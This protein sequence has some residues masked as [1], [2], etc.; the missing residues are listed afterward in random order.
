LLN[1]VRKSL[2]VYPVRAWNRNSPC[3]KIRIH[4]RGTKRANADPID[5]DPTTMTE[6]VVKTVVND[7]RQLANA[8]RALAMD[9]VQRANSGHPGMPMGMADIA[10][11]LFNDF[12]RHN[13]ANPDWWNRDRFVVSN[14]HGSMLL[15]AL[16]HLTGYALSIEDLKNFRQMHA[17]TPGHPEYG[18][19]PGVETTT[20]PLGQGLAN[21]VGMALAEKLLAARFNRDDLDLVDHWTW[22]FAGD[23]CLME[24]ISHEVCSLAGT[25]KLGKLVLFYD[26]NGISIDGQTS[27]WF[28][29]D[30]P[31]RFEAYGWQV[32]RA[33]DG[34]DPAAI[35]AAIE[36][37][38]ADL[39][40][41]TLICCRTVIGFGAPNKQ[42]TA[43]THGAPLGES[44]IAAARAELGWPH[45]PFEIPDA[46]RQGWD[47]RQRGQRDEHA[48]HQLWL[49]YQTEHPE[50]AAEF[51]RRMNRRLPDNF[52]ERA[53]AIVE[54]MQA[55]PGKL[56]T[57][58]ASGMS[59]E[60]FGPLLPELL[61]GSADLTG[62]NNTDW[63]GSIDILESA[64]KGNYIYYG[65]REFGMTAIAS[66][67]HLH[68]GF[69]PYTGT[70]LVF[71][72]YARNAVRMSALIP[73]GVIHV[74]THD[75]IGLG[76]DGPTHQ[77]IEHVA[78]LRL[79]PNLEVWRPADKAETAVAWRAAIE[80]RNGPTALIL[81]RQGLQHQNRDATTL[82]AIE[83]GGYVLRQESG[84]VQLVLIASGSE[85]ELATGAADALSS[86]GISVRVVSM[87]NPGRFAAQP[88]DY[89]DQV[90]PAECRA[91][92][93]IEAGV[94]SYWRGFVGDAG[95]VIGIDHFGASAPADQLFKAFGFTVDNLIATAHELLGSASD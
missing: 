62:S 72:D 15:Y 68:G 11:V 44:E 17:P 47:A 1:S 13:P 50:A 23:G 85:L 57:R 49:R 64:A 22:V 39:A 83:R 58:K 10:E 88:A 33:V 28:T 91:R 3:A 59:L 80:R 16:L 67:M 53:Q 87:P 19:A 86:E 7:R 25:W 74:Y 8:I 42:G 55:D 14:G 18:E 20:G 95:R 30:T 46:V 93:A 12:H 63:S 38:R 45:A 66:G 54:A 35:R 26:D 29:D 27:G 65:V 51:E 43:D 94:S 6:T 32:I 60:A 2:Q 5:Q 31:A 77:P 89:R 84:P 34:H 61:G 41:P 79:I 9:A 40:R 56:A 92:V 81:T 37:A 82:A 90:L 69:I 75:S 52:A 78:S 76:E 4:Q 48:W 24:G 70:F 71:S 73:T 21:A 36:A